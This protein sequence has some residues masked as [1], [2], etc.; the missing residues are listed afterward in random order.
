MTDPLLQI[1]ELSLVV[2]IGASGSGKSTFAASHF[3][4]TEVISS[5]YC[6]ALV[7]DDENDQSV[8][9]DA[10]EVL[11]YIAAKRLAQGRLTVIDATNVSP[12][13]RR[14]LLRLAKEYHC[15]PV[16][17][18]LDLPEKLC[19][20]RNDARPDRAFGLHVVRN[21]SRQLKRSL[22]RLKREGFRYIHVL[23][24]PE[25][26]AQ[27]QLVRQPMWTDKSGEQ[28]PFDI[29]GDLHGCFEELIEL[30]TTLGYRIHAAKDEAERGFR[31]AS[32]AGRKVIFLGDLI[33]RGPKNVACL[34]LVMDMVESGVALC[35]PGNHE[36]KLLKH[37]KGKTVQLHHGLAETVAELDQHGDEAFK[38]R[39]TQFIDGLISHYVL[40]EG[41]LVV[42]HAGM[43]SA[44]QGRG[45]GAVR[46]FALYGETTGETDEYGLPVRGNWAAEYRGRA[47]VVYGHTPRAEAEFFN[48]TLCVDTGCVFGGQLTALR[49]PERELVSVAA[50]ETYC[51]PPKPLEG[52]T[53]T[54]QQIHDDL[55]YLE[56][57]QGK[58]FIKTGHAGTVRVDERQ[59]AAALEVMSRFAV[60]PKWIN[61]LPPTMSPTESSELPE[62]LEHP[63]EAFAYYRRQGVKQVICEEKH[64]GS[65][66]VVQI[67]H[68]SEVAR[69][70]FGITTG[71][72][73]IVYTRTGRRFFKDI[74][75]EQAFLNQLSQA[76]TK[77]E[78]WA[79]LATEWLTLDCEIMPWS[80]KAMD[81]IKTQ[82]AAVGAASTA[83][84]NNLNHLLE[85]AAERGV[86]LSDID[87]K[88]VA[89]Q[90]NAKAF[91]EAYGQYCW[92]V[93]GL[94]DIQLAPF[95]IMAGEAG[96][97]VDR[98]HR[99]HMET[100]AR[101]A[102]TSEG[103]VI[104]TP[105][106]VV[107]I[108]DS[109]QIKDAI[110]WW[111]GLT[112]SGEGMVVKPLQFVEKGERGRLQPAIKV[113]GQ[114]YLRLIYGQDYTLK[115]AL[116]RLKV[117]AL[118]TKRRLAFNEFGL[119]I[120]ALE[121]FVAHA[122][123]RQIHECV[124]AVLAMNSEPVDP[125]L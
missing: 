50:K 105:Y 65:R 2:L 63:A 85:K 92:S 101:I 30:L 9:N 5:D 4:P 18:V 3:K 21:Q 103:L 47:L 29:I 71:E 75:M 82:Y 77:A 51:Q 20:V 45:S 23:K 87:S 94:E 46:A 114:A 93:K 96:L 7:S 6:R 84:L 34:Q 59:S 48:N 35:V 66:A 28:G 74:A 123:L 116:E 10:F 107:D 53:L 17:I 88:V 69:R 43:K 54:S 58:R 97:F 31:V 98:D 38:A 90:R 120:E 73:G 108:D 95:H 37:L 118:G 109:L 1:P 41:R 125:R 33:D 42:A 12:E 55:L 14:S 104:K 80:L 122:P 91:R 78:L 113:R 52:E 64:M 68:D 24:D 83:S 81:L 110:D 100:I 16:A 76:I 67:C 119:G 44:F 56:D 89:S 124:F 19:Q 36:V 106:R 121:R 111:H 26:I 32:P 15:M 72:Q 61:Y 49:Y 25:E 27:A 99:W 11:H 62:F 13:S 40:D 115:T 117:R 8:T 79:S 86:S 60:H 39:V 22:K 70:R 112:Q 57:V 102:Q